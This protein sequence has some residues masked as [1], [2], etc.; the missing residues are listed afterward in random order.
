MRVE[1]A[2][3]RL[4]HHHHSIALAAAT[5]AGTDVPYCTLSPMGLSPPDR[6]FRQLILTP[7]LRTTTFQH[8]LLRPAKLILTSHTDELN[9][10]GAWPSTRSLL[11]VDHTP[12][13]TNDHPIDSTQNTG[14]LPFPVSNFKHCL[15][16]FSKFF[17]SFPH[18]TC[19]LS[20]SR[21]YLALD[22]TYHLLRAA[23]PN[24]P[25]R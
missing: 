16:F 1:T 22:E 23:I 10:S 9:M 25:T 20:V 11:T 17:S 3:Q 6:I 14:V 7:R 24:N 8:R 13:Y 5:F 18:G 21:R 2:D 19:S 15:T 12:G 4:D